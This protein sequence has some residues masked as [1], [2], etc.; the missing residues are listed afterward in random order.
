MSY[1]HSDDEVVQSL[2]EALKAHDFRVWVDQSAIRDFEGITPAAKAGLAESKALVAFY[3]A[4]YPKSSPCQWELT[5]A[6]LAAGRLGD[7]RQR[8]L[9]VNPE[10]GPDHIE[11]VALR[12]ALYQAI[13]HADTRSIGAIADA[14]VEHIGQ[15]EGT[16][17]RGIVVPELWLP[18]T[19]PGAP[20]F[21]G[22]RR[23]MWQI[24]SA[25][26]GPE[27]GMTQRITGPGAVVLSGMGGVG[28]SLLAQEYAL[29]YAGGFPGGVFWLYA[30]GDASPQDDP[31]APAR[32]EALELSRREQ[33][34]SFAVSLLGLEA[35]T[36]LEKMSPADVDIV[37]RNALKEREPCLWVVDDLPSGLSAN[38]VH[39]WLGSGAAMSLVTTRSREYRGLIR[40]VPLGTLEP[41]EAFE[42]LA[43]HQQPDDNDERQAAWALVEELGGHAL[44]IDVAG[45][46]VELE[47]FAA[48][49]EALRNPTDDALELAAKLSGEL[50]TG[51][52]RSIAATL[53]RS[54]ESLDETSR[55]LL[56]I[57]ARVAS[58][59]IPTSVFRAFLA[60]AESEAGGSNPRAVRAR[61][62]LALDQ[63]RSRSLIEQGDEDAWQIH[64]L[65]SRTVRRRE[66]G[67]ARRGQLRAAAVA[68][69]RELL[70]DIENPEQLETIRSVVNH[71]RAFVGW[72]GTI[73]GARL[74]GLVSSYEYATL[75]YGHARDDAQL[76]VEL[77]ANLGAPRLETLGAMWGLA[78][79]EFAVGEFR[80]AGGLEQQVLTSLCQ[81][82]W[83][84]V[85][86]KEARQLAAR[87]LN[88]RTKRLGGTHPDTI[89]AMHRLADMLERFDDRTSADRLRVIASERVRDAATPLDCWLNWDG[90]FDE[91]VIS[92]LARRA[93]RASQHTVVAVPDTARYASLP[94]YAHHQLIEV[95]FGASE[96][97]EY[98]FG[99]DSPDRVVWL[100]GSSTPIHATNGLESLELT[101]GTVHDY[102]RFFL[103]FTRANQGSFL[104]VESA[105]SLEVARGLDAV[106]PGER[107]V[108]LR[109]RLRE[110][111]RALIPLVTRRVT[112]GGDWM[113]DCSVALDDSLFAASLR[114]SPSGEIE[115]V[116]DHRIGSLKGVSIPLYPALVTITQ[117]DVG[118][119]P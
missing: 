36:Q 88:A 31:D 95:R 14:I 57:G 113:I 106:D 10:S 70:V 13:D 109:D 104:L 71:A 41:A 119:S 100:D 55:D 49:L 38:V 26:R 90:F 80:T 6:F 75:N 50:P 52:E 79:A 68:A 118:T 91:E 42:L 59:P 92:A 45:A 98:V 47:S 99:L 103:F 87:V 15:L 53:E 108:G 8:V 67:S 86:Q 83:E 66:A 111:R 4:Q 102:V 114:V 28:K 39:Q 81:L 117:F 46:L 101:D 27:A 16:L 37:L 3:S 107:D 51:H 96:G 12:D 65:I 112:E 89:Q 34:R 32:A 33:V 77:L 9:V 29:R 23:E 24:E 18:T 60:N 40:E 2:V 35:V 74:L 56:W 11:P 116:E 105:Q 84:A 97:V 85:E 58:E 78:R 82:P 69:L 64:P 21:M 93:G 5:L 20:R 76:Q 44:A 62:L 7:P 25:L 115:M 63:L 61:L 43:A 1:R 30:G 110:L 48:V 94:F 73:A 54:L 17:G 19:I 72:G 22:R